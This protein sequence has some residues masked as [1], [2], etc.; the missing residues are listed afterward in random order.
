MNG[1]S[2]T[3]ANMKNWLVDW[4]ANEMNLSR[5]EIDPSQPFLGYGMNSVQAMTMVGDIEAKLSLRLAPTLAW[6]YPNID[7]LAAH[8]DTF[9]GQAIV[10][11]PASLVERSTQ[12]EPTREDVEG[13]LAGLDMLSDQDV[14]RLLHQFSGEAK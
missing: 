1:T 13:L 6:D 8:L 2:Q 10:S 7:A 4:L 3:G 9:A 11:T 14:D 12:T 5:T